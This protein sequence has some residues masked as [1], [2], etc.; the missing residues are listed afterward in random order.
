[1]QSLASMSIHFKKTS[2]HRVAQIQAEGRKFISTECQKVYFCEIKKSAYKPSI[3]V[4]IA[5][6]QVNKMLI[7]LFLLLKIASIIKV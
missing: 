5:I 6:A 7:I 4:N 2:A 1:M 3:F